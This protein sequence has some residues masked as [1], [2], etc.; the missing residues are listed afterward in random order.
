MFFYAI[1]QENENVFYLPSRFLSYMLVCCKGSRPSILIFLRTLNL[2]EILTITIA[3][4]IKSHRR[5]EITFQQSEIGSKHFQH[6]FA[7]V[8]D[9]GLTCQT[10]EDYHF[11]SE[12]RTKVFKRFNCS[13][14]FSKRSEKLNTQLDGRTC[15]TNL[16]NNL[17][18]LLQ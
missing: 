11:T 4:N 3:K 18:L 16:Y 14:P 2:K 8:K 10:C 12:Q 17:L 9:V 5:N 1:N 7:H 6:V 15:L 13:R